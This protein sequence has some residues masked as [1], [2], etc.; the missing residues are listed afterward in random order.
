MRPVRKISLAKPSLPRVHKITFMLN[1]E[2]YKT[3]ERYLL[4]Y[5]IQNKSR[6]YRE[7]I[8]LHV[9]RTLE[10]DYPTLFKEIEMRR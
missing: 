2:E 3:V 4:K 10:E 8:L 5:N 6:W 7:T 9:L 1:E